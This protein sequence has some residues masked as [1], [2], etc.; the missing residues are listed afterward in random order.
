MLKG[1][2]NAFIALFMIVTIAAANIIPE[3]ILVLSD[4]KLNNLV[5]GTDPTNNVGRLISQLTSKGEVTFKQYSD[6]NLE[7]FF[8]GD[9]KYDHLVL[10]PSSKKT[11]GDKAHFTA[12]SLKDFINGGG[13]VLIVGDCD[14]QQPEPIKALLNDI[15][16]YPS[17]KGYQLLDHFNVGSEGS[18]I[19][20]DNSNLISNRIVDSLLIDSYK[21]GAALISGN[22]LLFPLVK[23]SKTSFTA[24]SKKAD[25]PLTQ[26]SAWTFGNQ[27]FAAVAFQALNNARISWVG[28]S[29]LLSPQL[30]LWTLKDRDVLKLQFVTHSKESAPEKVDP[31]IYRV[32]EQVLY[33]IGVSELVDG[34]WVPFEVKNEEDKLQLS[35]KMLDPYQRINMQPLGPVSSNE[36]D[37]RLDTYAYLANFTVPDHHGVFTFELDYKRPGL[38]YLMDNR[39]VTVRHLANDEFK[40]SWE[41]TNAWLYVACAGIV[42]VAWCL[43]VINF[44]YIGKP[45]TSKKHQ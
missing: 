45:N 43:F 23:G 38:S 14:A 39:L 26:E 40:R 30:V 42:V 12:Q 9:I 18:G 13:N 44:I 36:N 24:D 22:E 20:L 41:I 5:N 1:I 37:S 34:K 21:G 31:K 29:Q 27:G 33:T 35:F 15:G 25:V 32:T 17:P 10:L 8:G 6:D 16:I 7:V 4:E 2:W 11:V 28:S 19:K 3:S